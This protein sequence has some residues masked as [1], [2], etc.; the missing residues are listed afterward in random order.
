[1]PSARATSAHASLGRPI[2]ARAEPAGKIV[3]EIWDGARK[4]LGWNSV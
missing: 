3:Q 2:G 1:M 4:L